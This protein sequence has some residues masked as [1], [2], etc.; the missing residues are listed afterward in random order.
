MLSKKH[1][2]QISC[3]AFHTGALINDGTVMLFV[4][5]KYGQLGD[6]IHTRALINEGTEILFGANYYV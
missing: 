6:K 3:G 4:S 1:V 5:N 2:T